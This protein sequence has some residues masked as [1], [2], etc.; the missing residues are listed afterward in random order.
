MPNYV[1]NS[2]TAPKTETMRLMH[3][4]SE[5]LN[6]GIANLIL[7]RPKNEDENWYN[8]NCLNWGNKWGA[9]RQY[10]G[11]GVLNFETAWSPMSYKFLRKISKTLPDF[12]YVYEEEQGWGGEIEYRKGEKVYEREW[13]E[14]E[15]DWQAPKY[16]ENEDEFYYLPSKFTRERGVVYPAG[17]YCYGNLGDMYYKTLSEFYKED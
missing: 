3:E 2:L 8:W 16:D 1:Y 4:E 6:G 13:D 12:V 17:W 15:F 14:P 5:K 9:C 10:Y 7:P 11:E